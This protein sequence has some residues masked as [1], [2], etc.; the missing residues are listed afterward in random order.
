M[1]DKTKIF[2]TRPTFLGQNKDLREGAKMFGMRP[3]SFLMRPA[4]QNIN[5][6]E[7]ETSKY[8]LQDKTLIPCTA[9]L[10]ETETG[11]YLITKRNP[12]L[13][14]NWLPKEIGY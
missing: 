11:E 13:E 4:P 7:S 8:L 2:G 6:F 5:I 14:T 1:C 12:V 3:K 10:Y 9:V